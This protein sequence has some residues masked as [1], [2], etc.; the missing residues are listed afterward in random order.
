MC[1]AISLQIAA[2]GMSRNLCIDGAEV[3]GSIVFTYCTLFMS[4]LCCSLATNEKAKAFSF[5]VR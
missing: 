2:F 3:I 5:F 4:I 1:D